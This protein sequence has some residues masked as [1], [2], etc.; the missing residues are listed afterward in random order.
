MKNFLRDTELV[1]RAQKQTHRI[2]GAAQSASR[3]GLRKAGRRQLWDGSVQE[4]QTWGC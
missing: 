2:T 3:G 4:P 1:V